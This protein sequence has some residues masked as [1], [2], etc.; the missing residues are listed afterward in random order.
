MQTTSTNVTYVDVD[1]HHP[2]STFPSRHPIDNPPTPTKASMSSRK[3]PLQNGYDKEKWY[4]VDTLSKD[5]NDTSSHDS[6]LDDSNHD[7]PNHGFRVLLNRFRH[8]HDWF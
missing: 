6:K 8:L 5:W 1:L 4:D 7:D 3:V 2:V